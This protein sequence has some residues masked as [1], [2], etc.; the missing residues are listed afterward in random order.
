MR[1]LKVRRTRLFVS[2]SSS[3]MPWPLALDLTGRAAALIGERDTAD[4]AIVVCGMVGYSV[5]VHP[6]GLQ[7]VPRACA[8]NLCLFN[9]FPASSPLARHAGGL[10]LAVV[11]R[12]KMAPRTSRSSCEEARSAHTRHPTSQTTIWRPSA[13]TRASVCQ[14]HHLSTPPETR[15]WQQKPANPAV[16]IPFP[17]LPKVHRSSWTQT[18]GLAGVAVCTPRSGPGS[19]PRASSCPRANEAPSGAN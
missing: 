5:A 14:N 17:A 13:Q 4:G 11:T 6:A 12:G 15:T 10:W 2:T 7:P 9:S 19:P 8:S 18:P 16:G 3:W 1:H